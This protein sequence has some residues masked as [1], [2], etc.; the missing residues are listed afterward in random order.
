MPFEFPDRWK[1]EKIE[2]LDTTDSLGKIFK[3]SNVTYFDKDDKLFIF[4]EKHL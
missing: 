4:L 1:A 3:L 2:M